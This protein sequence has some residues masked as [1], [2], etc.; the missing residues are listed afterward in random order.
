MIA[1][2]FDPSTGK[3]YLFSASIWDTPSIKTYSGL[4]DLLDQ[5]ERKVEK[6]QGFKRLKIL[7]FTLKNE[8]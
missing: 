7:S 6:S 5:V 1:D 4:S 8:K 2:M 3:A